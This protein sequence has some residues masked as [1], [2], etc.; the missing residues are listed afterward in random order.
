MLPVKLLIILIGWSLGFI[1]SRKYRQIFLAVPALL[2]IVL[3]FMDDSRMIELRSTVKS[4]FDAYRPIEKTASERYPSLP[5]DKAIEKYLDDVSKIEASNEQLKEENSKNKQL[6]SDLEIKS[7]ISEELAYREYALYNAFG[8]KSG[9]RGPRIGAINGIRITEPTPL[10][11]WNSDFA[12]RSEGK[13]TCSCTPA[14]ITVCKSVIEKFP[15]YPF[16]YYFLFLCLK[17]KRDASWRG[18]AEKARS[19]FQKTTGMENHSK[20]HDL[21][22]G[23]LNK[24]L[25]GA[26][27]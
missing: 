3:L 18:Y 26:G 2:T 19:I 27:R 7:K 13:I 11:D 25:A 17:E 24:L 14:A 1:V 12:S 21:V 10:E 22:L 6:I 4:L 16:A 9:L 15:Q 23:E 8:V 20:D 5:K